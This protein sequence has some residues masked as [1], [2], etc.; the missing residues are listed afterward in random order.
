MATTTYISEI[1]GKKIYAE[2]AEYTTAGRNIDESLDDLRMNVNPLVAGDN[3]KIDYGPSGVTIS[4]VENTG[5]TGPC[6]PR[7]PTGATGP[8]GPSGY[9]GNTGATGAKGPCGPSGSNGVAGVKGNTGAIGA[10]GATG[11]KGPCGP[12]GYQGLTG[13]KGPCGP[14]GN[15]GNTGVKGPCGPS[16]NQGVTGSRGPCGPQGY[17]GLTGSQGSRGPCGP[18]GNTGVTGFPRSISFPSS[19]ENCKT[20]Q[21][22]PTSTSTEIDTVD[23]SAA[24]SVVNYYMFPSSSG[25][26]YMSFLMK[27]VTDNVEYSYVVNVLTDHETN[28]PM[29]VMPNKQYKAYVRLISGAAVPVKFRRQV[30]TIK[31]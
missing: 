11:A 16:G 21:F 8:C 5:P 18:K 25:S 10:T 23:S 2:R 1:N 7:G 31:P 4:T 12:N 3:I 26:F 30:T 20:A 15:N 6:G 14:S 24:Y 27:N 19:V 13:L 29:Y 17:Q 22:T 9:T 28:I